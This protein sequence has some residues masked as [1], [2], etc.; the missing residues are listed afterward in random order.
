MEICDKIGER[1]FVKTK[2]DSN[3]QAIN[4]YFKIQSSFNNVITNAACKLGEP[5]TLTINV[6]SFKTVDNVMLEIPIPAGFSY[7]KKPQAAGAETYR[8]YDYDKTAIFLDKMSAG[9]YSFTI[10]L[11]PKF[12]GTFKIP[13]AKVELMYY[14]EMYNIT[15]PKVI[16][17]E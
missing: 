10:Q 5:I 14:P 6:E 12:S 9:A 16:V 15:A 3:P 11:I 13:P 8:L 7:Y 1:K 17:V 2:L 4:E